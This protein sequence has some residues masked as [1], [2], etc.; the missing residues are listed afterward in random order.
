MSHKGV[1]FKTTVI[2]QRS[3]LENARDQRRVLVLGETHYHIEKGCAA[4][5]AGNRDQY[6]ALSHTI[7]GLLWRDKKRY[8]RSFAE[9]VKGNFK[10]I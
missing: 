9:D 8:V 1:Q 7:R 10:H 2:Q 6:K 4:R 5:L 3:A